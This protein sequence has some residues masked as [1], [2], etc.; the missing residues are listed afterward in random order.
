M[1]LQMPTFQPCQPPP[2]QRGA[3]TP[4]LRLDSGLPYSQP[5]PGRVLFVCLFLDR[6]SL[7]KWPRTHYIHQAASNSEIHLPL[8]YGI[9]GVYHHAQSFYFN[10]KIGSYVIQ[11][12]LNVLCKL[13][14]FSSPPPSHTGIACRYH[15]S[16]GRS[17]V[18]NMLCLWQRN[19]LQRR[20]G[21]Q[22]PLC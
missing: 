22:V 14:I 8:T 1:A 3:W 15:T 13:L 7:G 9:K 17:Q 10:F 18:L 2:L 16:S 19:Q 20:M 21:P 4:G 5:K 12:D 6:V 11:V